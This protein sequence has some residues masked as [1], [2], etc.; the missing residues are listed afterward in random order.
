MSALSEAEQRE[1]LD[2]LR[3]LAAP[4]T[5]EFRKKFPSRSG[6][7]EPGEGLVDTLAGLLSNAD[8]NIDFLATDRRAQLRY[9]A[10]I[11]RLQRVAAGGEPGRNEDDALLAQAILAEATTDPVTPIVVNNVRAA[12][13]AA[14][15]PPFVYRDRP[16]AAPE[17]V[18]PVGGSTGQIIGQAYD[19]LEALQLSGALTETEKAPLAALIGVLQTKTGSQA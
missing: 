3:W 19:A 7:R 6:V 4:D 9:P 18:A 5:G 16:V 17:P 14:S 8:G 10:A 11:A 12:E 1:V 13:P 2:L 15:P